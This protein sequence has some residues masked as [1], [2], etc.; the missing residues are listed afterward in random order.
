MIAEGGDAPLRALPGEIITPLLTLLS[1]G[2]S[3]PYDIPRLAPLVTGC[4]PPVRHTTTKPSARPWRT[5]DGL[6]F[7]PYKLPGHLRTRRNR[8][9][10]T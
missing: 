5:L 4:P 10:V 9:T 8:C 3:P 1:A 7:G 6:V 2:L